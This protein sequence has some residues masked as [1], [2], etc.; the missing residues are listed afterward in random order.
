MKRWVAVALCSVLWGGL[1]DAAPCVAT[2]SASTPTADFIDNGDGTVTHTKT[3]LMWKQCTEGLSGVGCA[4]GAATSFTWQGALQA[5]QALNAAGGFAGYTDWRVPNQKELDSIVER[6]C[7]FP[8]IN[9]TV[10]PNT[11]QTWYWSSSPYAA[12][13]ALNW[14]IGFD[15][16]VATGAFPRNFLRLVRGGQ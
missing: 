16:G 3:G 11:V 2:I 5:A 7:I 1:A 6:Q 8:S 10:F 14:A 4:T 15:K 9:I 12:T 13:P